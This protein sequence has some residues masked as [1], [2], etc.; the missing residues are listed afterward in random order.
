MVSDVSQYPINTRIVAGEPAVTQNHRARGIKRSDIKSQW[1]NIPRRKADGEFGNDLGDSLAQRTIEKAER[2]RMRSW[3]NRKVVSGNIG[4]INE[5]MRRTRVNK[6]GDGREDRVWIG[7][8]IRSRKWSRKK[9][10]A[11]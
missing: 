4:G 11:K 6:S 9:L 8:G 3:S 1:K 7:I 2:N 10:E 5:A